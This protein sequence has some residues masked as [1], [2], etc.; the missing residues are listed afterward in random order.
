MTTTVKARRESVLSRPK[1]GG[2]SGGQMP[3]DVVVRVEVVVVV[4]VLVELVVVKA[5][6]VKAT[7]V[8]VVVMKV[9][10]VEDCLVDRMASDVGDVAVDVALSVLLWL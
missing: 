8:K 6:V 3:S 10:V 4:K 7:V 9:V 1:G 5:V 2:T